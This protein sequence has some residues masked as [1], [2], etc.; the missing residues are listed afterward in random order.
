MELSFKLREVVVDDNSVLWDVCHSRPEITEQ[1]STIS[2]QGC[3]ADFLPDSQTESD[4]RSHHRVAEDTS[5]GYPVC[6]MVCVDLEILLAPD[7]FCNRFSDGFKWH[8]YGDNEI[9]LTG[10]AGFQLSRVCRGNPVVVSCYP[11]NTLRAGESLTR[12]G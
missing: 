7:L 12:Q 5:R 10:T 9:V 2:F 8:R 11:C 4:A 6:I 1:V 3:C